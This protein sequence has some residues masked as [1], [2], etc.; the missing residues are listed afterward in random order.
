M[1]EKVYRL[2][3]KTYMSR[4]EF[5]DGPGSLQNIVADVYNQVVKTWSEPAGRPKDV[6]IRYAKH[7]VPGV[8]EDEDPR[9][10]YSY[11]LEYK[12]ADGEWMHVTSIEPRVIKLGHDDYEDYD[13]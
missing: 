10:E 9:I 5:E 12:N 3:K 2:V 7:F 6:V 11:W 8:Y 4:V 1:S 13:E